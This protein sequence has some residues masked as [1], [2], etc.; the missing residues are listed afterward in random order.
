[1]IRD[2][3]FNTLFAPQFAPPWGSTAVKQAG[4]LIPLN[5][6]KEEIPSAEVQ[7]HLDRHDLKSPAEKLQDYCHGQALVEG[8]WY[9]LP[10]AISRASKLSLRDYFPLPPFVIDDPETHVVPLR[11]NRLGNGRGMQI[12]DDDDDEGDEDGD[13]AYGGEA[14]LETR[15]W[16]EDATPV[17]WYDSMVRCEKALPSRDNEAGED[18]LEVMMEDPNMAAY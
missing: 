5:A 15:E 18:V 4:Y 7:G 11:G 16:D 17:L 10:Q 14:F 12:I 2:P 8:S 9:N 13:L 1:M 3:A 6:V